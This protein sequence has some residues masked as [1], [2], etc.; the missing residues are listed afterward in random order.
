MPALFENVVRGEVHQAHVE[1]AILQE[2]RPPQVV[3]GGEFPVIIAVA[4]GAVREQRV[5]AQ[6]RAAA[7]RA[8]VRF[9]KLAL[10]QPLEKSGIHRGDDRGENIP[11]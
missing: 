4:I 5:F 10:V 9:Q 8:L 7:V 6:R 1:C 11:Q 2:Q 3:D